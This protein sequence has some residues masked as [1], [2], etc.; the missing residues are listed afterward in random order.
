MVLLPPPLAL[1]TLLYTS[2]VPESEGQPA[3]RARE[4]REKEKEREREEENFRR[5]RLRR[6][7]GE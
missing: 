6:V 5:E 1:H 2:N 4:A 7:A 3:A